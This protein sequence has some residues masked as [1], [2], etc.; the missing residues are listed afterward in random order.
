VA[1]HPRP[2]HQ[3]D[4]LEVT[5]ADA[6]VEERADAVADVLQRG[7]GLGGQLL[8]DQRERDLAG[9]LRHGGAEQVG[10]VAEVVV[11]RAAGDPCLGDDLLGS[12]AV[13]AVGREQ[14]PRRRD[15]GLPRVG[16]VLGAA[17]PQALLVW[18]ARIRRAGDLRFRG[19]TVIM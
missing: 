8:I 4:A 7:G 6:D 16:G 17:A 9:R 2:V 19:H 10:L 12:R 13:E 18:T 5:A 15:Q 1:Q 11:Q 3:D 14:P